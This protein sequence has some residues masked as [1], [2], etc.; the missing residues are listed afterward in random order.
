MEK[1]QKMSVEGLLGLDLRP[2]CAALVEECRTLSGRIGTDLFAGPSRT[3]AE[4]LTE[5]AGLRAQVLHWD[6]HYALQL[7]GGRAEP[8]DQDL[9]LL[10]MSAAD[11]VD[12]LLLAIR[13]QWLVVPADAADLLLAEP[14]L[15]T[16]RNYLEGGRTLIPYILGD[17]AETA[18]AAREYAASTAWL[19][20]YYRI[21]AGL[22]PVVDGTAVSLAQARSSLES[23]DAGLR[24]RSLG[25]M[26]DALEPVAPMFAQCLDS[27]VADHLS[28]NALRGLPHPRADRDLTNELPSAAVD[29]MLDAVEA[30]YG[31]AQRWFS[32]KA[33]LLGAD[34]LHI[35]H[36]RAPLGAGSQV[37]YQHAVRIVAEA[38]G[39]FADEAGELVH[40]MVEAGLVDAEPREGK[41]PGA[42]CRSLGPGQLPRIHM[43]YFGTANDAVALAHEF[44]HALQFTLAGRRCDGLTYDAPECLGEI[45][46]AFAE[47]LVYDWLIAN[48]PD[49]R[50]RESIA[51]RRVETS[52]DAIFFSAFLTR[53]EA[54]AHQTRAEG[55]A[56]T[57]TRIG[58][59]W[60]ECGRQFY[61][62]DVDLPERWGELHW[63]LV[64]H[65]MH[66]RFYAY[67]Y[68]FAKLVGLH[69]YAA[70]R[71]DPAGFRPRF[72]E[73][74]SLG[75]TVT[76]AGQL[77]ALGI[78]LNDP[79]TWR[80][81]LGQFV[82]LLAPLGA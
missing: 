16:F 4:V 24:V 3:V 2:R 35:A 5:I 78:D 13:Q 54:R 51:A 42:F 31:L 8:E 45:A 66:E 67:S 79:A 11:A 15:T 46:P 30:N 20:L 61:G 12:D 47:L 23:G 40:T 36:V 50:V 26:Y 82:G 63:M 44:G 80:N 58:E 43:S 53:F 28:V 55:G 39:G 81:G 1:E 9:R 72:L 62:P 21:S 10:V 64:A 74:L 27:L 65:I 49:P 77:T 6:G 73:V 70:Y 56:L 59:L 48:E 17:Q 34:R 32:R 14:C 38:F 7:A 37:P 60:A 57:P 33:R 22:R 52:I 29:N 68:A 41:Q 19:E 25:A 69:L 71:Q 76:P 18:L 75:N